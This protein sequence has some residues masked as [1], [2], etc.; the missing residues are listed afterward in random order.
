ML[1]AWSCATAAERFGVSFDDYATGEA[2]TDKGSR[3]GGWEPFAAETVASNVVDGAHSSIAFNS[4][5]ALVF[6]SETD[7]AE[8]TSRVEFSVCPEFLAKCEP[9]PEEGIAALSPAINSAGKTGFYGRGD[10]CWH[11]L[12]AEGVTLA[13]GE[14][15]HGFIETRQV[16]GSTYVGYL[17]KN[18]NGEY[19]R[20]ADRDGRIWF[21][22]SATESVA[23]RKVAFLG[24]GKF[25]A[26]NGEDEADAREYQIYHWIGGESGDWENAANWSLLPG[27]E[28]A[29]TFPSAA[30]DFAK[31]TGT[32]ALTYRGATAEVKD[33]A[34]EFGG[35]ATNVVGGELSVT[36]MNLKTNRP[37]VG[38][39][40]SVEV[41]TLFGLHPECSFI[42]QRAPWDKRWS[43]TPI[44]TDAEYTPTVDD[45]EHWLRLVVYEGGGERYRKEFYFSKLPVFYIDTEGSATPTVKKVEHTASFFVQGN[46][47]WKHQYNGTGVVKVRGNTTATYPK[48]PYKVKLDEKTNMFGMGKNKH[49][50]LLANYNDI[51]QMRN[52]LAYDFANAIGSL[53]MDSTWVQCVLNGEFVGTYQFSEHVRV[54]SN[55]VDIFDW[56]E[57]VED[58]TDLS[59]I[60]PE[61]ED[62]SGGYL[63]EFSTEMDELTKF[64]TNSGKLSLPTMVS[65]PE[66]LYTNPAMLQYCKNFLQNYW[67]ACTSADRLSKEDRHYSEYCDV[68]SM[69]HF[70]LVEELFADGCIKSRFAY[71]DR[72]GKLTW[73]PVW[74]FDWGMGSIAQDN[75]G[76]TPKAW[77]C[78]S[79]VTGSKEYSMF[80]EWGSDFYF[81]TKLQKRYWE[82]RDQYL[83]AFRE[84]GLIDQYEAY[85]AEA[86]AA[87]DARWPRSRSFAQDVAMMRNF[88]NTRIGWLD[89]Q[90][91]SVPGLVESLRGPRQT[92]QSTW[93][94]DAESGALG[95]APSLP[96]EWVRAALVGA[97]PTFGYASAD[98]LKAAVTNTPSAWGKATP[99]WHDWVAGTNPDPAGTNATLRITEIAPAEGAVRLG[100]APNLGE[101]RVYTVW[102][103]ADLAAGDWHSPT[104]SADRFFKV[105]VSLPPAD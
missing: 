47:E 59:G 30:G 26:F 44:S 21:C 91:E 71:L 89:A 38:H 98:R 4:N 27:G 63:F 17:V 37:R 49:W 42:W 65:S 73:G 95:E 61:T 76:G 75:T 87:N 6:A 12:S 9:P 51:A 55:R 103:C 54:G 100:W 88:F 70:F 46:D 93:D 79:G 22:G 28:P 2:L 39:A 97:D 29:E 11:W 90:F 15:I 101:R 20:L 36:A 62:I 7:G 68:D 66:Y 67:D 99:L 35:G 8:A 23:P 69:V 58:K 33:F 50:V 18:Q 52:K 104:N 96:L 84:G 64:T 78:A 19:V 25:G 24:V 72:G 102:G 10:G 45:Y 86:C 34:V 14:W 1:S 48:K 56:E 32:V 94:P 85:L 77:Y 57:A 105:K 43:G 80:K 83:E 5:E 74:D 60:D 31:I 81:C 82:V 3:G 40:L 92:N 41:P 16:G 53:G 13:A